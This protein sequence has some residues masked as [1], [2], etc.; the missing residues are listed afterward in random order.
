MKVTS[1]SFEH[2]KPKTTRSAQLYVSIGG[3]SH[4]GTRNELD[5]NAWKKVA[6]TKLAR[7]DKVYADFVLDTPISIAVGEVIAFY[8]ATE[9]KI[10]L[11][12]KKKEKNTETTPTQI[13][14]NEKN[15][16]KAKISNGSSIVN[17]V[18]GTLEDGIVGNAVVTYQLA[19]K[20]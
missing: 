3:S 19:K 9:D 4:V 5:P 13:Q 12:G 15:D 17:E 18:M 7:R 8:I 2:I 11:V 10:L 14:Q 20:K 16:G 1:I 6:S